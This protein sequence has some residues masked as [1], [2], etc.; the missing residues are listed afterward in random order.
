MQAQSDCQHVQQAYNAGNEIATHTLHHLEMGTDFT[1]NITNEIVGERLWLINNCSLPAEDVVGFRSPY[2]INNPLHRQALA[3]GGFLY[4]STINEHWPNPID[5]ETYPT[6]PN[7]SE[8][9]WPYTMDYGIPEDCAWTGNLCTPT[10]RYPGLWEVPVWVLQTNTY[11]NPAYAMDPCDGLSS[12]PCNTFDLFQSNFE[13][14]YNGNRAPVPIYIHSPWLSNITQFQWTQ[15]IIQ[16]VTTTYPDA[17]FVTMHQLVQWM[18]NPVPKD[19]VGAWLGCAVPG[20]N[21]AGAKAG[22]TPAAAAP[23]PATPAAP[24][25]QPTVVPATPTPEVLP[26]QTMSDSAV[27]VQANTS[28]VASAPPTPPASSATKAASFAAAVVSAIAAVALLQ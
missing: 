25:A 19:Q 28:T 24:V 12:T 15:Q 14:A 26:A 21:A 20:G 10:E 27:A 9:L 8:R 3:A 4:D 11:P 1:G 13:L 6:S 5:G 23:A 22:A 17:Y 7:G 18:Q 16:W 2:L